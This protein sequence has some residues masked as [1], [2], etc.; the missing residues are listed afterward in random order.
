M[1]LLLDTHILIW[2]ATERKTLLQRERQELASA[3]QLFLS[4]ISLWEIRAKVRAERKRGKPRLTIDPQGALA[5]CA[6]TNIGVEELSI[7]DLLLPPLAVDPEHGDMFDEML[8][9]E[10]QKLK[11]KLLTRDDKLL[12]HPLSVF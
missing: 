3:S 8:L 6:R 5:F 11:A 4:S 1:R 2:F 10:A 7:A 9:V 12:G